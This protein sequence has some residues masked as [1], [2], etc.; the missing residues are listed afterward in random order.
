MKSRSDML[1]EFWRLLHHRILELGLFW[2]KMTYCFHT[3]CLDFFLFFEHPNE[4]PI[5]ICT[6]TDTYIHIHIYICTC[7]LMQEQVK[8][9]C[10]SGKGNKTDCSKMTYLSLYLFFATR[11]ERESSSVF[12]FLRSVG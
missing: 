12:Y 11:R 7:H 10:A 4:P 6:P 2:Q 1:R 5:H 8:C 9:Y 3:V